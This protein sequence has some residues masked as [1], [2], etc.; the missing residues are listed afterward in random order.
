MS[1]CDYH[2]FSFDCHCREGGVC[3]DVSVAQEVD[4]SPTLT[5]AR[6]PVC[7]EV[8][9]YLSWWRADE[10]GYG[11]R[12]DCSGAEMA[13]KRLEARAERAEKERDEA[14]AERDDW[15]A[16]YERTREGDGELIAT[17]A[18]ALRMAEAWIDHEGDGCSCAETEGGPCALCAARAALVLVKPEKEKT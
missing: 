2:W 14:R 10:G 3:F 9:T 17:L 6:C 4:A 7:G 12:G 18:E 11:S 1:E 16:T 8:R 15:L 13:R 5:T